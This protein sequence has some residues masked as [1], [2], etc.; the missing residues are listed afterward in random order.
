MKE[1]FG[2]LIELESLEIL[3]S[4]QIDDLQFHQLSYYIEEK[5]QYLKDLISLKLKIMDSTLSTL[6]LYKICSNL[7][8]NLQNLKLIIISQRELTLE[9]IFPHSQF[10]DLEKLKIWIKA[11]NNPLIKINQLYN[12][13]KCLTLSFS[14]LFSDENFNLSLKNLQKVETLINED[15]EKNIEKLFKNNQCIRS[16]KLTFL[17]TKS[18]GN[19]LKYMKDLKVLKKLQ[20]SFDE[21][22][23]F[24]SYILMEILAIFLDKDSEPFQD[25]LT[26]KLQIPK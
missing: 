17:N 8:K 14:S 2:D 25:L 10:K 9:G 11:P 24:S 16:L 18:S 3:I 19:L 21:K 1:N 6:N 15:N 22:V 13:L 23:E 4:F 26:F 20:I 7:P 12:N 5:L